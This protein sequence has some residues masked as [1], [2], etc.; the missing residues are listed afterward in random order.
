MRIGQEKGVK[1]GREGWGYGFFKADAELH[2]HLSLSTSV[3]QEREMIGKQGR[4]KE[5]ANT[6]RRSSSAAW[7]SLRAKGCWQ[8]LT[9]KSGITFLNTG[10]LVR[11]NLPSMSE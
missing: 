3:H 9:F 6:C 8:Q 5:R 11:T 2:A 10:R 1:N 7:L 4:K